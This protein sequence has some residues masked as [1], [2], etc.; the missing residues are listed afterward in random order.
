MPWTAQLLVMKRT[1]DHSIAPAKDWGRHRRGEI[2]DILDWTGKPKLGNA[3]DPNFV[4]IYITGVP[5]TWSLQRLKEKILQPH[6]HN[7]EFLQDGTPKDLGRKK[8]FIPISVIPAV[9]LAQ[10]KTEGWTSATWAQVRNL[11]KRRLH[12]AVLGNSGDPADD[13]AEDAFGVSEDI[14]A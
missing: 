11:M 12:N 9:K 13:D 7:L 1:K 6:V 5:A 4:N 8:Y 2:I 3:A 14:G 10:L